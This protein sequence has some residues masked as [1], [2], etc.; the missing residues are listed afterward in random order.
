M[1]K[2]YQIKFLTRVALEIIENLYETKTA[3]TQKIN[4]ADKIQQSPNIVLKVFYD[5]CRKGLE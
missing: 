2:P 1:R 5:R 4:A 3:L